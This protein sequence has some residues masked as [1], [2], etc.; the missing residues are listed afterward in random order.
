MGFSCFLASQEKLASNETSPSV[1]RPVRKSQAGLRRSL[2]R[3][4]FISISY[5]KGVSRV[6]F[7]LRGQPFSTTAIIT[8]LANRGQMFH[9]TITK[10]EK[11]AISNVYAKLNQEARAERASLNPRH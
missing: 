3:E 11:V 8:T 4:T 6:L 9:R 10:K 1:R 7:T 5:F 2:R